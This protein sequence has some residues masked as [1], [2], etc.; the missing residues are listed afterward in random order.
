M[1]GLF[2]L[3]CEGCV[4]VAPVEQDWSSPED[5]A[6]RGLSS[7]AVVTTGPPRRWSAARQEGH[8]SQPRSFVTP[9]CFYLR[10]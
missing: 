10:Y 6:E 7:L 1:L 5:V 8:N 9:P 4:F 3:P 2:K